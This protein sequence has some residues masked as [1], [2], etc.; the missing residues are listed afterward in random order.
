MYTICHFSRIPLL[1]PV[2]WPRYQALSEHTKQSAAEL[3]EEFQPKAR[4][5][6][7]I[8]ANYVA[9]YRQ[10]T[11]WAGTILLF[12]EKDCQSGDMQEY[13]R[14]PGALRPLP[15]AAAAVVVV[16]RAPEVRCDHLAHKDARHAVCGCPIA[17]PADGLQ[18]VRPGIGAL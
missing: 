14:H 4:G 3:A 18:H 2:C 16:G 17:R 15:A 9:I 11:K 10:G 1:L 12:M 13:A 5:N 8:A 6:Q 7:R